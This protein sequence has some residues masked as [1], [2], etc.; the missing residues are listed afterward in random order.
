MSWLIPLD[1]PIRIDR[2]EAQRLAEVELAKNKYDSGPPEWLNKVGEWLEKLFNWI[3]SLLNWSARA[4]QPG[5]G[6]GINWGFVIAVGVLLI[7][8]AI[9]V[10]KVGLPRWRKPTDSDDG[11]DLDPTR[12]PSDYRSTSEIAAQQENWAAAV[13]DRY[14]ALVRDLEIR[15]IL[16]VRPARTAWEAAYSAARVLPDST[17]DLYTGADLFND[18]VYGDRPAG[19]QHY[20]TLVGIDT[21]V[22]AAADR[23]DLVDAEE[24]ASVPGGVR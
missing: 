2:D 5:G 15:T 14:R 16:D 8:I 7:L 11:L 23:T 19:E 12:A 10:W 13:R 18:V 20:L 3:V 4:R 22:L 9:V 24:S 21:R 1:V 17:E 6:G